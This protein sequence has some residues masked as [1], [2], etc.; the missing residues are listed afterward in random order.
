[1]SS[2]AGLSPKGP[3]NYVGPNVY[4]PSIVSRNREPLG[5]DYRQ[6]E[7]G[8]LYPVGSYWI[9]SID[10]TTGT[11][12]DLWYLSKIVANVAYWIQ[13]S[14]GGP[15]TLLDVIVQAVTAPGVNPVTPV[16]GDITFQ[17]AVVANHSVPVETRSRALHVMNLEVQYA[18]SAAAT[19]GTKSGLAHFNSAQFTVDSSGFVSTSGTGVGKTI[20]GDTGGALS[21]TA[22]NWNIIG[23]D[24]ITTHGAVSTLTITPRGAGV[25]NMFLG[26][27]AGNLTLSGSGNV[28]YGADTCPNI[29]TGDENVCI[30]FNA[31]NDIT[32][33]D[34]NI[35]MGNDAGM[36]IT[37]GLNNVAIG[38]G[39]LRTAI[40]TNENTAVGTNALSLSTGT[41]CVAVGA[42]AAANASA[43][44]GTTA[45]GW[46]ALSNSTGA[47]NTAVGFNS[48]SD[49]TSGVNNTGIGESSGTGLLTGSYN[50]FIGSTSGM[51]YNGAESSNILINN[52]GVVGESHVMRLGIQGSG[53]G[54][55]INTFVAGIVGITVSNAVPV[56][57]DSTTGQLGVGVG[58]STLV[59]TYE[60]ADS[61]GTWTKNANTKFVE[62]IMWG[63]GAGGGSGRKGVTTAAG[64]GAGGSGAGNVWMRGPASFF[65]ASQNFIVGAGGAGAAAQTTD[66]TDG[67][68]GSDGTASVFGILSTASSL[69][70]NGGTDTLASGGQSVN[71]TGVVVTLRAGEGGI[72]ANVNGGVSVGSG[73]T[74]QDYG[75]YG[76]TGGGGGGG[77]DVAVERPGGDAGGLTNVDSTAN[78]IAGSAGGLEST[79]INGANAVQPSGQA[80]FLGG[81]GGGGGGGYS[82]GAM[83]ATTGGR[84]GN[85][86]IPGGGGGGGGG[87]LTAVAN[88]GAGGNGANGRIIVIEYL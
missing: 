42:A 14:S 8:K 61:P 83:G 4:L 36:S 78:L 16:A 64:G 35:C 20:T 11:Q 56:M 67:I 48:L 17:G 71:N 25:A 86:A 29:T 43:G 5:S 54:G 79:G 10:P 31:G 72:G 84:G 87:G 41:A 7:T 60:L 69:A 68:I 30:G 28:S 49:V 58:T 40:G 18:T 74:A 9:I 51:N 55:I 44:N 32:T 75:Y 46:N 24:G 77:S 23:Q 65:G 62:V 45:I 53:N 52:A 70:G 81:F 2:Q 3:N 59:T 12:G 19:D 80:A 82:V 22:G 47:T 57:I 66:N 50:I 6:P 76:T 26:Q 39:A 27:G 34:S 85:G 73:G 21:P 38:A 37:T 13:L 63:G 33:G 88:S 15:G 1:M